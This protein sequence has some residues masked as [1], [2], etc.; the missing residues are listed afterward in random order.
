MMNNIIIMINIIDMAFFI[1]AKPGVS[2][3]LKNDIQNLHF[4]T[5]GGECVHSEHIGHFERKNL[6]TGRGKS[7]SKMA[8]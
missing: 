7:S 5:R 6:E 1:S 4:I 8:T 2:Y 3:N